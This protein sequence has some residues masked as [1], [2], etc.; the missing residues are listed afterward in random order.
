MSRLSLLLLAVPLVLGGCATVSDSPLQQLELHAVLDY[1][2]VG[3][4]GCI[5]SNDTGRW[6]VV[7]PGRVTVTR[8]TQPLQVSCKKDG[9]MMASES[10][11][12]RV[13]VAGLAGNVVIS[14]GV[15]HLVDRYTG[16]GFSY[17]ANLTVLME[18]VQPQQNLVAAQKVESRVF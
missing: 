10:F 7:A 11:G 15:G 16:A 4:V 6:F 3:G 12:S 9:A 13:E 17:P 2:E 5:L 1:K 18:P 8:S 14:A